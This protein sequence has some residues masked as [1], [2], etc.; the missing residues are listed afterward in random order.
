MLLEETL[1]FP[2]VVE[3]RISVN[4]SPLISRMSV[5]VFPR[6]TMAKIS[7]FTI[8]KMGGRGYTRIGIVTK[9]PAPIF[10][11]LNTTHHQNYILVPIVMSSLW[12]NERASSILPQGTGEAKLPPILMAT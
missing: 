4:L 10:Q 8:T 3:Y 1:K 6:P 7:G 9:A 2:S 11:E 5:V 12:M